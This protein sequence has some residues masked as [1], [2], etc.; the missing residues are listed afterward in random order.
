MKTT[1][2][3]TI[4]IAS[5][6]LFCLSNNSIAQYQWQHSSMTTG[7]PSGFATNGTTI[8]AG[9][10]YGPKGV[11]ISTDN[12]LTWTSVADAILATKNVYSVFANGT[13]VLAGTS[14]GFIFKS[15]DNGASWTSTSISGAVNT[16]GA[17][18]TTIFA[19][20]NGVYKSTD[21]GST[22]T[23]AGPNGGTRMC[24]SGTT[25]VTS[26][27][28]ANALYISTDSGNNWALTNYKKSLNSLAI[29]GSKIFVGYD[30]LYSS[31]DNGVSWTT[32]STPV[33]PSGVSIMCLLADGNNLFAGTFAEGAFLSANN[34]V[35]WTAINS[36]LTDKK[37]YSLG[38]SGST[39]LAGSG[40]VWTTSG[41][42]TSIQNQ[43]PS[44]TMSIYP[45][46]SNGTFQ[47]RFADNKESIQLN[48]TDILG[49]V[50][51][52]E[53]LSTGIAEKQLDLQSYPNGVY[54]LQIQTKN[55]I[56]T[57]KLILK[58]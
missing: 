27:P 12:G 40:G 11:A 5:L 49:K 54:F 50:V 47:L 7:I 16:F 20:A 48:V 41:S 56:E 33:S 37:I 22:W 6:A 21:N 53:K 23:L 15:T 18:G 2:T 36:G 29:I 42:V 39:L 52:S 19:G 34:G 45:N 55:N 14:D 1:F 4:F 35:T 25:I 44:P 24:I 10:T 17:I 28:L 38:M 30:S 31:T 26:K 57:K 9:I 8:F 3:K 58:K 46:P 13:V 43:S 32:V 51:Y